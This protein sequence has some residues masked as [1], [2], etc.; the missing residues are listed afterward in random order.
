MLPLTGPRA[1]AVRSWE[2]LSWADFP[3]CRRGSP[4]PS[5][6][7]SNPAAVSKLSC[8]CLPGPVHPV[9]LSPAPLSLW[10]DED[11][12]GSSLPLPCASGERG[13]TC[14]SAQPLCPHSGAKGHRTAA[15]WS[16][17]LKTRHQAAGISEQRGPHSLLVDTR[18]GHTEEWVGAVDSRS[19]CTSPAPR[20]PPPPTPGP[21][22]SCRP[23]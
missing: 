6:T 3:F 11:K 9:L 10:Q 2:P 16:E 14:G 12:D 7:A 4:Q 8:H 17:G 15:Y 23:V 22:C 18:K 21:S 5:H 1:A 20:S 19:G 13:G